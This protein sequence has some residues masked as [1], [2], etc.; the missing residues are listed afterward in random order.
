MFRF[1]GKNGSVFVPT[2][3]YV[4]GSG[5][6]MGL[7][8]VIDQ[9]Y[10]EY[11]YSTQSNIASTV[12]IFAPEDFPDEATGALEERV[13]N[14]GQEVFLNVQPT[15]INGDQQLRSVP[16]ESRG[17]VFTDEKFIIF[18]KF[19]FIHLCP[20]GL[21]KFPLINVFTHHA[22][23]IFVH[24]SFYSFS[25]CNL[26]CRMEDIIQY[27]GC[28][29]FHYTTLYNVSYCMLSDLPCLSRWKTKWYNTEPAFGTVKQLKASIQCPHCMPTCNYIRYK[30]TASFGY[31]KPEYLRRRAYL[32]LI[33]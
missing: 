26:A 22:L 20:E 11:S 2:P 33:L 8:F 12:F 28:Y 32:P 16:P 30:T 5:P 10:D 9:L 6:T 21:K 19:V 13:L 17:C 1:I 7:S 25:E 18:D 29:P 31:I 14:P 24:C 27:C 15:P 23:S 4:Y 3:L